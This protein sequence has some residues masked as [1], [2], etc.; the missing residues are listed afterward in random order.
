MAQ[1]HIFALAKTLRFYRNNLR[2]LDIFGI[3]LLFIVIGLVTY[4]IYQ[5]QTVPK[6]AYF[7]TTSDGRLIQLYPEQK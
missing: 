1:D 2:T 6:P 3:L 7:A 5:I 4:A